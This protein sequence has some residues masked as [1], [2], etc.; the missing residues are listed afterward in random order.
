MR[1][2]LV[3]LSDNLSWENV[4]EV[5]EKEVFEGVEVEIEG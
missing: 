2:A 1:E 5:E 3:W 4:L